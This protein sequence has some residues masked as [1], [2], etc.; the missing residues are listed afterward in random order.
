MNPQM[1]VLNARIAAEQ[2]WSYID[3][4]APQATKYQI[5][6]NHDIRPLKM[7][8]EKAPELEHMVSQ[9]LHEMMTFPTVTT[10]YDPREELMIDG[11]LYIHGFTKAGNHMKHFFKNTIVGHLHRG[12]T[13]F[14]HVHAIGPLWELNAGYVGDVEKKVFNYT[15][16]RVSNWTLG[17]GLVENNNPQFISWDHLKH[18]SSAE[19]PQKTSPLVVV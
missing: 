10:I 13:L 12:Y 4:L 19:P 8:R 18:P 16:T 3:R 1:E 11:N 15:P 14:D 2:F 9:S 5:T 17:Y 7:A 6:G